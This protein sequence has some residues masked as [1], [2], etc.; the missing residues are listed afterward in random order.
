MIPKSPKKKA[1]KKKSKAK[2]LKTL[3]TKLWTLTSEYIRKKYADEH[4]YVSCVTC[5]VTRLWNDGIQAGHFIPKAQG[6]SIYFEEENIHPQC[7]PCNV[8]KDGNY[9]S[10]TLF[11][12]DTYGREKIDEL[13]SLA[14]TELKISIPEYEERIAEIKEQLKVLK[15]EL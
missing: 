15:G 10:Y 9:R 6:L 4:G 3:K 14:K 11:M 1:K 2:T 5:G 13:E 8:F 7:M 12:I